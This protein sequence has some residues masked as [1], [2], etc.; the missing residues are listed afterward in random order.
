[1]IHTTTAPQSVIFMNFYFQSTRTDRRP[2][3][4]V[5]P[6]NKSASPASEAFY[7]RPKF[8]VFLWKF[9]IFI[10]MMMNKKN[11]QFSFYVGLHFINC[12][13]HCGLSSR[14]DHLRTYRAI[15]RQ[16]KQSSSGSFWPNSRTNIRAFLIRFSG[17]LTQHWLME[18]WFMKP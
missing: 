8:S 2:P 5:F 1:M 18:G 16:Q 11:Y 14:K 10:M 12:L 13:P 15:D 3:S 4:V 7:F 6:Q 17:F 9:I